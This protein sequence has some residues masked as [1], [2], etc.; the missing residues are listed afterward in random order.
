MHH[1]MS[2]HLLSLIYLPNA[3]LIGLCL[4]T[5]LSASRIKLA[6]VALMH[7]NALLRASM[8]CVNRIASV[9]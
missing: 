9:T 5:I 2:N 8:S 1:R 7:N 4:L 6:I 3:G